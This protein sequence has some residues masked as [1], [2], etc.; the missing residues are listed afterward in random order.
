MQLISCCFGD[1]AADFSN[2][3]ECKGSIRRW[4]QQSN[5]RLRTTFKSSRYS[6]VHLPSNSPHR[7]MIHN[8]MVHARVENDEIA[9]GPMSLSKVN[10]EDANRPEIYYL[11]GIRFYLIVAAY[12]PNTLPPYPPPIDIAHNSSSTH[13][14]LPRH[15]KSV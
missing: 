4:R 7:R 12:V 6:P 9:L 11:T 15:T 3:G 8:D 14:M 13:V 5:T 2:M 10:A 1:S